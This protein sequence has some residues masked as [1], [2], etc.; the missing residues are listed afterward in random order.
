[1]GA[2]AVRRLT[3]RQTAVLAAVERV[4]RPVMAD[5]WEQFPELA[6]SSIKSVLDALERRGLVRHSGDDRQVYL[7]GVTWWSTAMP[8][9][10]GAPALDRLVAALDRAGL[11]LEQ[12]GDAPEGCVTAFL[13]IVELEAELQ[14]QPSGILDRLRAV[15]RELEAQGSPVRLSI[16]EISAGAE[17]LVRLKLRPLERVP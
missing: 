13:P 6:P 3:D 16:D 1:V 5:L 10:E 9:A 14:S 8:G 12:R 15:L 7:N 17:P 11:E 4:G 2:V